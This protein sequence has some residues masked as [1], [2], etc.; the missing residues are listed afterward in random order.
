MNAMMPITMDFRPAYEQLTPGER[1]FVDGYVS[2]LESIA[3]KTGQ[4]LALV[5]TQPYPYPLDS[6]ALALLASA[7]VRTAIC[8][9][10]KALSEL[11]DVSP[12]RT[13]KELCALAYS[14]IGDYI[15]P[16]SIDG[17]PEFKWSK[18]SYEQLGAIKSFEI[19][20]KPRGG[21][22]YKFQLHDKLGALT[23]LMEYMALTKPDNPHWAEAKKQEQAAK[24]PLLPV[25][26]D[27]EGAT[28]MWSDFLGKQ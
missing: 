16:N 24:A 9:R 5:L 25:G 8:E 13:L 2:D 4:R 1:R 6:R 26:I 23:K 11:V 17:S 14:N 7:L 10:V 15:E 20:E 22:R 21:V 18:A 19:E 27:D 28:K 3:E 12:Y